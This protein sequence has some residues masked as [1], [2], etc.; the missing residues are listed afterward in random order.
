MGL[1]A[2]VGADVAG[3]MLQTVEGLFAER[4]LVRA[5]E[6]ARALVILGVL[7]ERRHQAHG[8]RRHGSVGSGLGSGLGRRGLLGCRVGVEDTGQVVGTYRLG[9]RLHVIGGGT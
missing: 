1:L 7:E 3:L 4:A 8:S 9:G 2:G 5:R 6:V